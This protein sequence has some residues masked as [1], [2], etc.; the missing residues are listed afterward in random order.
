MNIRIQIFV[1]IHAFIFLGFPGVR[2]FSVMVSACLTSLE[3][4]KLFC[5][6]TVAFCVPTNSV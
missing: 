4:V 6:V 2:L 3:I 5:S 1:W